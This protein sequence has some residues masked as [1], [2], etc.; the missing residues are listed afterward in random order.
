MFQC[1]TCLNMMRTRNSYTPLEST[2]SKERGLRGLCFNHKEETHLASGHTLAQ[3][4]HFFV[5]L[6]CHSNIT[7]CLDYFSIHHYQKPNS[8]A[9]IQNSLLL[10]CRLQQS[11]GIY[12]SSAPFILLCQRPAVFNKYLLYSTHSSQVYPISAAEYKA[13][14][15]KMHMTIYLTN[16]SRIHLCA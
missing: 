7:P 14:E 5:R 8:Q 6:P 2:R 15:T 11:Q 4:T 9:S 1:P 12:T 13:M 3:V 16:N 10:F